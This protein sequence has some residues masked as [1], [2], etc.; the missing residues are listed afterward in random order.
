MRLRTTSLPNELFDS[1]SSVSCMP[2]P[3]WRFK[4]NRKGSTEDVLADMILFFPNLVEVN[5][6]L[7]SEGIEYDTWMQAALEGVV[8]MQRWEGMVMVK[9]CKGT[10][11]IVDDEESGEESVVQSDEP[12]RRIPPWESNK[13]KARMLVLENEDLKRR[14]K[15]RFEGG[16]IQFSNYDAPGVGRLGIQ[17]QVVD[18]CEDVREVQTKRGAVGF[19]Y[20]P[21]E[22]YWADLRNRRLVEAR[23]EI[24]RGRDEELPGC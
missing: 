19:D 20:D 7:G 2:W 6:K 1:I 8:D 5:V 3:R 11:T 24:D 10:W 4:G 17:L 9:R 12:P 23:G 13:R 22:E 14:V 18:R 21:G 15:V 16:G